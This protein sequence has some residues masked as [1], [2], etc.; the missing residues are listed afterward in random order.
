MYRY[1][2]LSRDVPQ[3]P[4]ET[5]TKDQTKP[6]MSARAA[7]AEAA[8]DALIAE[9]PTMS[10]LT[11]SA[12]PWPDGEAGPA[13]KRRKGRNSVEEIIAEAVEACL[14]APVG[15]VTMHACGREDIDVRML[16]EW[17]ASV[18]SI[19]YIYTVCICT[20]PLQLISLPTDILL[21]SEYAS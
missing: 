9:E 17:G 13:Q 14:G 8:S 20:R 15:S 18:P 12:D 11:A 5:D 21:C 2:K 6:M 7:A 4:W 10:S 19:L 16:G 1:R 3:T